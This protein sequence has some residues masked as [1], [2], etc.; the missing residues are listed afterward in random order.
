MEGDVD[1]SEGTGEGVPYHDAVEHSV[2]WYVRDMASHGCVDTHP[3]VSPGHL[4]PYANDLAGR[5]D[6]RDRDDRDQ[7]RAVVTGPAGRRL[8]NRGL[9][10]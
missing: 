4:R 3:G 8:P 7:K 6:F 10:E 2:G 1:G 9:T 5:R